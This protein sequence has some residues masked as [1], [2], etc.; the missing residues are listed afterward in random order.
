M[1]AVTSTFSVPGLH[2]AGCIA[3]L[4]G[5]LARV[6][7]V[8][9]SRVNF[10][11][12]R[13]AIAHALEL[14]DDCLRDAIVRIG[15]P[16]E[17]LLADDEG[18]AAPENRELGRAL[19]VAGFAAMNIMLLSVSVWSGAQGATRDMFHW[20]SA[21]IALPTV[22]YAG[23]PFYRSAWSALRYGRTNM[24]VP[25]TIGVSLACAVSLYETIT[26][27]PHAYFDGAVMLLFFLLAGRFLDGVMRARA[28]DGVAALQRQRAPRGLVVSPDGKAEWRDA[29]ELAPGMKLLVAAGEA[30]A[31]DGT[32]IEG[33]SSVDRALVTGE[34]VPDSVGPG[35]AVL[36]GTINLAAP[37]TIKVSAAGEATAIAGIAR[38]MEAA[39]GAKS[40]YV[41][42]ADRAARVYAPAVHLL[43]LLAFAGWMLAGAGFHQAVLIA[44]AVLIITCPCALGLA[45]PV[46][47]VVAAGA[48][49][50]RGILIRDGA[51]LERLAEADVALMDKTGTLTLGRPRLLDLGGLTP[52]EVPVALALARVSRHPLAQA[53]ATALNADIAAE[54][55]G[56]EET[57]GLGI[58]A[59]SGG[60][61]AVLGRI[62][63]DANDPAETA[64]SRH[65]LTTAFRL[66]DGPVRLIRFEDSLRPDATAAVVRLKALG[67]DPTI[68]SGDLTRRVDRLAETLGVPGVGGLTPQGKL[69]A[70]VLRQ[71]AGRHVLMVGDGLNDGPALSAAHVSMAPSSA[72]DV[73]QNSADLIFLGDS[74]AAV[75]VALVAARRTMRV[76][77]QNFAMAIGYNALAVPIAMAGFATPLV[78]ALAMSLSSLLVVGN[79]LRLRS[80][81]E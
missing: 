51:G 23:R 27:G 24:D 21:L 69:D 71:T 79:S 16:A 65:A 48:L 81:A 56:L 54:V 3:K 11:K 15:F 50:R 74:L 44:V 64:A 45:V 33:S 32:V 61:R 22:V 25:I 36:A 4:E 30:F 49:M 34:S 80:A 5:G 31:A 59:N 6:E 73:G 57:P 66:G 41:R 29:D 76:V 78:A 7:G 10:T 40:R 67:L 47:Q 72:S 77:R 39:G 17:R 52:A 75:P 8:I 9:G 1:S 38:L 62:D 35:A 63:A 12:R 68:V 53:L 43:A 70:I 13:V 20:L 46:A 55:T 2:C 18:R 58:T 19:G 14:D 26:H 42:L 60:N 37:L 28:E